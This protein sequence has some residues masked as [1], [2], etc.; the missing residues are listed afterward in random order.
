MDVVAAAQQG[1]VNIE[2]ISRLPVPDEPVLQDH[3]PRLWGDGRLQ[4]LLRLVLLLRGC[5]GHLD[6]AL[7]RGSLRCSGLTRTPVLRYLTLAERRTLEPGANLQ[8]IYV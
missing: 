8:R 4:A 1:T 5:L 3:T 2:E 6:V 7:P